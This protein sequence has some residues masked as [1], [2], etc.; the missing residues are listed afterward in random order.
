M[1]EISATVLNSSVWLN[2]FTNK[3]LADSSNIIIFFVELWLDDNP[4]FVHDYF[5]RKATPK[6]INDWLSEKVVRNT[7]KSIKTAPIN[8]GDSCTIEIVKRDL[9]S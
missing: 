2:L 3:I 9:Y 7:T 8:A 5:R 1:Y 4:D 6:M